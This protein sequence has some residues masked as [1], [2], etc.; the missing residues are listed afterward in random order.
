MRIGYDPEKNDK[1][2]LVRGLSFDAVIDLQW[3]EALIYVDDRKDYGEVRYNAFLPDED[4][5]FYSVT[6]TWRQDLMWIISFRRARAKERKRY[7]SKPR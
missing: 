6:F 5:R 7:E 2:H 3:E 4:G 1:T